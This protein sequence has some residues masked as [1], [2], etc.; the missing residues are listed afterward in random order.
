MEECV[1]YYQLFRNIIRG[2]SDS[3]IIVFITDEN[4]PATEEEIKNFRQEY[5]KDATVNCL[6]LKWQDIYKELPLDFHPFQF[7]CFNPDFK[8]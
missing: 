8:L 7:I 6:F 5:L 4:N 2:D 3:K 1:K